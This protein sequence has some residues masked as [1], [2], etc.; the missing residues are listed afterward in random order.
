MYRVLLGYQVKVL[1]PRLTR[2]TFGLG[3]VG[4]GFFIVIFE[5]GRLGWVCFS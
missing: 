5:L 4:F 2:H 3:R 1:G